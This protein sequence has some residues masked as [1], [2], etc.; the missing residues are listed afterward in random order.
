MGRITQMADD[1]VPAKHMLSVR[2]FTK[3]KVSL[4]EMVAER[5]P[6]AADDEAQAQ[7]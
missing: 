1:G 5:T 6:G 2:D 7:A 4:E 3:G